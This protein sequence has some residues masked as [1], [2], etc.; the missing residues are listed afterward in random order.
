NFISVLHRMAS[1]MLASKVFEMLGPLGDKGGALG[2]IGS[3]FG[4]AKASGG[5]VMSGRS[6]LVGEHGPEMFT[7]RSAGSITPNNQLS[8]SAPVVNVRN[9]NVLD[10][11]VVGD[12]L[13]GDEGEQ[14]IMNIVQRNRGALNF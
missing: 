13:G 8:G 7:P 12:Y 4:G 6:Y 5:D 1:E 3:F 9:I 10:P 2:F 14:L 11:S